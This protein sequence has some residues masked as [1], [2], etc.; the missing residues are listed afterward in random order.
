MDKNKSIDG[1]SPRRSKK[2]TSSAAPVKKTTT[3]KPVTKTIKPATKTIK[4]NK[5]VKIPVQE[6]PTAAKPE[7]PSTATPEA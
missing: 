6:E 1:L 3:K 7:E 2:A 4:I 5:P